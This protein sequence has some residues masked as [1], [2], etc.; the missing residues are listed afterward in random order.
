MPGHDRRLSPFVGL[1]KL[2]SQAT[3]TILHIAIDWQTL[4][5]ERIIRDMCEMKT[6]HKLQND[7]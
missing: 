4:C 2:Q 6:I 5:N 7:E 1:I 3:G